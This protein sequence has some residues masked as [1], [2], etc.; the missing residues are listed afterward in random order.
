[1]RVQPQRAGTDGRINPG[2]PPPRGFIAAV[3][4]L[5]MVASTQGDGKLITDLSTECPAL[6]E[7]E[8]MSIRGSAPANETGVLGNSFDVISVTNPA[9]LW[10]C[11][12]AFIDPLRSRPILCVFCFLPL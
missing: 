6:G 1:M 3:M 4:D 8:V 9:W 2:V 7:S 5:A 12:R 10:Q 11:Q